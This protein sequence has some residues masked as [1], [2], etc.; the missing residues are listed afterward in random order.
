MKAK[1]AA[2][3]VKLLD[4]L[5]V[6]AGHAA[7]YLGE[8]PGILEAGLL[9]HPNA[10]I[11]PGSLLK[12]SFAGQRSYGERRSGLKNPRLAIEPHRDRL[13]LWTHMAKAPRGDEL[14]A[15]FATGMLSHHRRQLPEQ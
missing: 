12:Q 10:N 9:K 8:R 1:L 4:N 5:D 3:S 15:E 7:I 2:N 14:D 11:V 13:G 6:P